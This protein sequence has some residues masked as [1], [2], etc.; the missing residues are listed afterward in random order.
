M[1][2]LCY[3]T[4]LPILPLTAYEKDNKFKLYMPDTGLLLTLYG[5]ATKQILL[6]NTLKGFAQGGIY[7]NF[8]AETHIKNGYSLHYYKQGDYLELEF[9]IEKDGEIIPIEVKASNSSTKSL[10]TFH[11]DYEPS[12]AIKLINGNTG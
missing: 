10:N 5:F 12:I 2:Y 6:N 8:I 7:E 3:N 1:E 9:I 4:T 11:D